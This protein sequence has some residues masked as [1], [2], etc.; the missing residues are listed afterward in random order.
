MLLA[1][2]LFWAGSWLVMSGALD[3]LERRVHQTVMQTTAGW[4]FAVRNVLVDGREYTDVDTLRAMIGVEKGDPVFAFDPAKTK[5]NIEKLSWVKTAQV[6]RRL[7]DT[8]YVKVEERIPLAL[9]QR[10]KRL[11]LI[12][13][14]GVILTDRNLEPWKNLLIVVGDDAPKK[15]AALIAMI[16]AEPLIEKRVEAATLMSGRRW[17]LTLKSGAEV[18]L[19]EEEM[20]LALRQLAI[21][22]EEEALLDKDVLSIDVREQGRITVRT[23]P[24]AVSDFNAGITPASGKPI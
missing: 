13:A 3:A 11:F 7:P 23:K 5:T 9:W 10:D 1:V 24:G 2:A 20:G 12:D 18:K 15:A 16:H 21:N 8:I 19:P 17:D 6:E 22:H 14:D 4:G